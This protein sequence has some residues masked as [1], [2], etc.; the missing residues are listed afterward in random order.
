MRPNGSPL[1]HRNKATGNPVV[2]SDELMLPA[3]QQDRPHLC[4]CEFGA[5]VSLPASTLAQSASVSHV[6]EARP[7]TKISV[8]V[9]AFIA[10]FV[11]DFLARR[12]GAMKRHS[13]KAVDIMVRLSAAF[14]KFHRVIARRPNPR[15]NDP[16]SDKTTALVRVAGLAIQRPH[17]ALIANLIEPLKIRDWQPLFHVGKLQCGVR[18]CKGQ[19]A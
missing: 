12:A 14:G 11:A 7:P 10:I 18:Q 3:I 8:A 1:N 19:L 5:A 4:F 16:A 17:S 15:R 6:I 13:D 9:A 2:V